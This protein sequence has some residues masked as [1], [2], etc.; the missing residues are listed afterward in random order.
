[1]S[2]TKSHK[3]KVSNLPSRDAF[4]RAEQNFNDDILGGVLEGGGNQEI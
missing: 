4:N 2:D 1:M 3:G